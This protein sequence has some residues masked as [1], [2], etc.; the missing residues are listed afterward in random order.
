MKSRVIE[1]DG[2]WEVWR[3]K[4]ILQLELCLRRLEYV[5]VSAPLQSGLSVFFRQCIL[6]LKSLPDYQQYVPLLINV[7]SWNDSLFV[8]LA[9][10][11]SQQLRPVKYVHRRL[12][13][14]RRLESQGL[15]FLFEEVLRGCSKNF[16]FF[17]DDFQNL[18][19]SRQ[20]EFVSLIRQLHTYRDQYP[21][22]KQMFFVLGGA[23]L[24]K[25]LDPERT[26]PFS[27]AA[28]KI[29]LS[30]FS[31]DQTV[32]FAKVYFQKHGCSIHDIGARYIYEKTG[33]HPY[34]CQNLFRIIWSKHPSE[35][36]FRQIDRAV[37]EFIEE[38]DFHLKAIRQ[39]ILQASPQDLRAL[40]RILL[41]EVVQLSLMAPQRF[42][43]ELIVLGVLR[44]GP[45]RKVCLRNGI[46]ELFLRKDPL[47]RRHFSQV[48]DVAPKD[49]LVGQ[50]MLASNQFCY[51]IIN[52]V[53][54]R[55]RNFVV[56]QLYSEYGEEWARRG[57]A[58]VYTEPERW[59]GRTERELGEV[60]V[61]RKRR[62]EE[63]NTLEDCDD[64]LICYAT[65][66]DLENIIVKNWRNIFKKIIGS[67][68]QFKVYLTVL[69][70]VRNKVAH[71]RPIC[72]R[73]LERLL[74][75]VAHLDRW[76][77]KISLL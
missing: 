72:D 33:G 27:N 58:G 6:Y 51:G 9:L 55:L 3:E 73:D 64:P 11:I 28:S 65:L 71:N 63:D 30:D 76:L 46:Y 59:R 56:S 26:S 13:K 21:Y 4:E 29:H 15:S 23:I 52:Q 2:I 5:I 49:L 54:N 16:I 74:N 32:E 24:W 68:D 25:N 7:S 70:R 61:L 62:E 45:D 48:C 42:L 67:Q 47:L 36:Q 66:K 41:G 1:R 44:L 12:E 38:G 60:L 17:L 37:E 53:E 18:S 77:G 8:L 69:N 34:F 75:A 10:E 43:E 14:F 57:L 31:E 40:G 22:L 20:K 35:V 19:F 39:R 50:F